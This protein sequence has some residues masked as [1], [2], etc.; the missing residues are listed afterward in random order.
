MEVLKEDVMVEANEEGNVKC[1][2]RKVECRRA[3]VYG[4]RLYLRWR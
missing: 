2:D 3:G 1:I 4:R